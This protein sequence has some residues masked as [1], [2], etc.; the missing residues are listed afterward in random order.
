MPRYP[1]CTIWFGK[2]VLQVTRSVAAAT[3]SSR[4]TSPAYWLDK[5]T[6]TAYIIQVQYPE[7]RMNNTTQLEMIPV[8]SN[9]GDLH[10]LNEVASWKRIT[11]PGEYDRL[12]QQRYI[13]ITANVQEQDLGT[14]FKKSECFN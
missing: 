10:T 2:I 6:G 3:S 11:M 8:S 4:F 12:N 13:T 9:N 5:T 7:Y 14:A 1:R